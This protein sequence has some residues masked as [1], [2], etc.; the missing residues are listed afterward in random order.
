MDKIFINGNIITMDKEYPK[1]EAI[2]IKNCKFVKVGSNSEIM[3]LK[4]KS[5]EVIDLDGKTV[6]PGF[7]DSHMHVLSYGMFIRDVKL[8]KAKSIKDVIEISKKYIIDNDIKPGSWVRGRGWN[9]DNFIDEK[10]FITKY[11]LDKISK[12]HPISFTRTCG[13]IVVSNS[14][15]MEIAGIKKGSLQVI[16]GK[17]D[18]DENGEP[19]GIFR[20]AAR[21]LIWD[22]IP[23]PTVEELKDLIIKACKGA[24]AQGV[25]SIHTDDFKDI[26]KHIDRVIEAYEKLVKEKKLI[27]RINEQCNLPAVE[28]INNFLNQGY[29]TGYG[30]EFF[31]IGPLKLLSDGSLGARTAFLREPYS[32]DKTTR[33]IE[34]LNQKELDDLIWTAHSNGMQ[35]AIHAIGDQIMCNIIDA[36]SKAQKRMYRKNARHGIIHCQIT[37]KKLIEKFKKLDLI[38]YIQP[39]FLNYDIHIVESRIGKERSKTSYNFKTFIEKNINFACGSDCPVEPL[40]VLPGIYAAVTRKDLNGYPKNG[41]LP[42]QRITVEEA[43]YGFTMGAAYASF[44]ED[45]KGSISEGKYADFVI[46]SN[47]L[48]EVQPEKIKDINV[49]NTYIGGD[50]KYNNVNK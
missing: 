22:A 30:N 23:D 40:D 24:V 5:T 43:L 21:N 26:P 49:L 20:E 37:D 44:E 31:K 11:D 17:F 36:I 3:K 45:T 2:A 9:Q 42:D 13:H 33:G 48:L 8:D 46:L 27:V 6:T 28:K 32:D 14:K 34:I 15:A 38:A 35:V 41:W 7:H 18:L 1:A 12:E 4:T 50:L 29:N 39:I 10:R 25:T 16:G 47:D 19:L